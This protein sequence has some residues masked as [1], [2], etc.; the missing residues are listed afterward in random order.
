MTVRC[1]R[2]H[3]VARVAVLAGM[4]ATAGAVSGADAREAG[5]DERFE[6]AEQ[7]CR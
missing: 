3:R 4:L 6:Q 1:R 5:V 2:S 7:P